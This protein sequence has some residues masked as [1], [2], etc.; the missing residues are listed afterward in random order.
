M[1]LLG[2]EA[3]AHMTFELGPGEAFGGHD[4]AMIHTLPRSD[5]PPDMALEKDGGVEFTLPNGQT[6]NG[7]ILEIGSDTVRV[8]FNHPLADLPLTFEVQILAVGD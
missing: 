3:G 8:D 2:S 4:A 1:L 5:F 6:L 7:A